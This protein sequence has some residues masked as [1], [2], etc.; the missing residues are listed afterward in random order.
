MC[1]RAQHPALDSALAADR[2]AAAADYVT[3]HPIALQLRLAAQFLR[4]AP[5]V[6]PSQQR[7]YP[8]G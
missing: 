1:D 6:P 8:F 7:L 5:A 2:L 4:S 3:G